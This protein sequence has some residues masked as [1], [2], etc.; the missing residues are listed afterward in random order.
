MVTYIYM[1]ICAL[2]QELAN[3]FPEATSMLCGSVAHT[4]THTYTHAR[5]PTHTHTHAHTQHTHAHIT[6]TQ[7]LANVF[8]E[9]T[10]MLCGSV[11][12]WLQ[13]SREAQ[14]A[15]RSGW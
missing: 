15:G 9:A 2:T 10:S 3:V 11:A 13:T 8:P 14:Q 6:H 4:H 12:Q 1:H 5:A 7:E